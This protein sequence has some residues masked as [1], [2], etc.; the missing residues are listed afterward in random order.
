MKKFPIKALLFGLL[1]ILSF[2]TFSNQ[3]FHEE[4]V[5]VQETRN[6]VADDRIID[7]TQYKCDSIKR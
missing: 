1:L 4:E 2:Y 7:Y 6:I 5:S 3:K